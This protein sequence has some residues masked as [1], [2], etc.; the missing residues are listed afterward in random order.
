M[1]WSAQ[2]DSK[3]CPFASEATPATR[4][5]I[6][7]IPADSQ[8]ATGHLEWKIGH[9]SYLRPLSRQNEILRPERLRQILLAERL[10]DIDLHTT[11]HRI[12]RDHHDGCV[13]EGRF[14]IVGEHIQAEENVR[15][16]HCEHRRPVTVEIGET[17]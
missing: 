5:I 14:Q 3:S 12:E 11:R 2:R 10:Q 4:P 1:L 8:V 15:N 16:D 7:T 6:F 17:E 9:Y 13:G